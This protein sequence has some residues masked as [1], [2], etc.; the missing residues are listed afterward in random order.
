MTSTV[1]PIRI[2]EAFD[3]REQVLAMLQQHAP[4]RA[5]AAYAPEGVVDET[6][7]KSERSV[8]P[9]FRGDWAVGGKP[10]V[11]GVEGILYNRKFIDAARFTFGTSLVHPEFV[12]VNINAP[13]PPGSIHVDVPSFYG[14]TREEYPLPFLRVMGCSGLFEP[15]RVVRAGAVSWFYDGMGGNFDYWPDGLEGPML[16]EQPPFGNVALMA[17]NDR[18]YHR[19]GAIGN[20][21]ESLPQI[22]VSAQIQPDGNGNWTITENG[23]ARAT[24]PNH[25]I[26][27][28]LLWKAE[29]LKSEASRSNLSL[30][31]IM[32]IITTDLRGRNVDF[33]VPSDPL[34]DSAWTLLLQRVY[35]RNIPT[36][37]VR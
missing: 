29:I 37:G 27:F 23:E 20:P 26:R 36:P 13:M 5:I 6:E 16:S 32:E 31:Q 19:I 3:S 11:E 18:M 30:E 34:V 15:W 14:A 24:Y 7:G 12:V 10:L 33:Q 17:D 35:C 22:S 8:L 21:H 2:A 4:Y 28:S 25:A 9:W 1:K